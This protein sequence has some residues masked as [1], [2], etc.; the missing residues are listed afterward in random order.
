MSAGIHVSQSDVGIAQALDP[1]DH[2]A[3]LLPDGGDDLP[4]DIRTLLN[5]G[6][7]K[8]F[9]KKQTNT[10]GASFFLMYHVTKCITAKVSKHNTTVLDVS[11]LS[12]A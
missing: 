8:Q 4:G 6:E 3:S 7:R 1:S 10:P 9:K 12:S 11:Y 2:L 5:E